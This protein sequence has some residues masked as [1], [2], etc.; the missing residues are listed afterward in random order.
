MNR[1][2]LCCWRRQSRP[3]WGQTEEDQTHSNHTTASLCAKGL[4]R[5]ANSDSLPSLP[6]SLESN[7]WLAW[8]A[9]WLYS[10]VR[11]NVG[12]LEMGPASALCCMIVVDCCCCPGYPDL[13]GIHRLVQPAS[14]LSIVVWNSSSATNP[15]VECL[16][17]NGPFQTACLP[18]YS[19]I[20]VT[21]YCDCAQSC[22]LNGQSG[23]SYRLLFSQPTTFT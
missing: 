7:A 21:L 4:L 11:T 8:L 16:S 1:W 15:T 9:H 2:R 19:E 18:L 17:D 23:P 22:A 20:T 14:N 3:R 12:G 13:Q 5:T 10:S 6:A